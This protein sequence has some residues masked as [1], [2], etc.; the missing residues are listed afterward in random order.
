MP[1]TSYQPA[2]NSVNQCT[3]RYN[4]S[5]RSASR[6]IPYN[7]QQR[8]VNGGRNGSGG[9]GGS[10]GTLSG[11]GMISSSSISPTIPLISTPLAAPPPASNASTFLSL[12]PASPSVLATY[13]TGWQSSTTSSYWPTVNPISPVGKLLKFEKTWRIS[14]TCTNSHLPE[15]HFPEL[16]LDRTP[17]E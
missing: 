12:E 13:P 5:H 3:D 14:A 2:G 10:G 1:H 4:S 11:G 8:L 16:L 7:T 6:S 17:L 9:G 15:Y